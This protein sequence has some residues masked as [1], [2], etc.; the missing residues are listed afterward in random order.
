[1]AKPTCSI[2]IPTYNHGEYIER[3]VE[4]AIRQ[5]Y[6]NVEVVVVDDGSTDNTEQRIK[7]FGSRII[8]HRKE[9][10]GLGAARNTGIELSGGAFLQFL[11]A[12]DTIHETKL[13][14]QLPI[15]ETE[16]DVAVVYS[17]CT[18]TSPDGEVIANTSYSLRPE[19]D[20]LTILLKRTLFSVHSAVV[21]KSA[22]VEAGMFDTARIA[23]EDWE[24]W[25]K[26]ALNGHQYRYI[27]GNLAHYDQRGSEIVTNAELMYRRTKHLLDKFLADPD[28][29][30]LEKSQ[31]NSFVAHQNLQLATRAYNNG[32][33][34]V[35]REHFLATAKADPGIMTAGYWSCIPKTYLRQIADRFKGTSAPT[36]EQL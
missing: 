24:L 36:P 11:D 26:I 15:M 25:L 34:R 35:S 7:Q 5:T 14:M 1:M 13:A 28:F 18:C 30:A 21:R 19:E 32:W 12:D 8:Y 20:V 23:Q 6:P 31:V 10:A 29:L 9:N 4:C 17:D 27:P 16:G 22:V 3:S 33:W 2:I